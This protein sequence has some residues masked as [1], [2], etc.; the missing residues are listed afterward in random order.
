MAIE[1]IKRGTPP[2]EV[3]MKST[4][5]QCKSELKFTEADGQSCTDPRDGAVT[6]TIKCPVC[7]GNVHGWPKSN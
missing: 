6:V 3:P 2:A 1:V 5:R 4:C 7:G